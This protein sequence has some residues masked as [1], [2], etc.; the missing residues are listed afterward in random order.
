MFYGSA[1]NADT[2]D[3]ASDFIM[4]HTTAPYVFYRIISGLYFFTAGGKNVCKSS[5]GQIK[6][7]YKL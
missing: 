5:D 1:D 4:P 2:E 3:F 7:K 6:V